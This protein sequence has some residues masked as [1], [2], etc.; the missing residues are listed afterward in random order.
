[1]PLSKFLQKAW[2]VRVIRIVMSE[3]SLDLWP[4]QGLDFKTLY[5]FLSQ[6]G[7]QMLESVRARADYDSAVCV[8]NF[9]TTL[10]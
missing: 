3:E 8:N 6:H 9:E 10:L 5:S 7:A 4:G 2:D 1:M